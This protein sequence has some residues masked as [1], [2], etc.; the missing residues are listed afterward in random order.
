L[1]S[2]IGRGA[3]PPRSVAAY[4]RFIVVL[5][6]CWPNPAA[7]QPVP[8]AKPQL[9]ITSPAARSVST[10]DVR[11]IARC[12]DDGPSCTVTVTHAGSPLA[13]GAWA[14]DT[15]V[16]PPYHIGAFFIE[17]IDS[18]GQKTSERRT[19]YIHDR[20]LTHAATF[21]E[22]IFDI[23]DDRVL[24]A[25]LDQVTS[26]VRIVDRATNVAQTIWSRPSGE[27]EN[28]RRGYLTPAGAIFIVSGSLGYRLLEWRN[29]G[30]VDLGQ[31]VIYHSNYYGTDDSLVVKG[32]WALFI[33]EPTTCCSPWIGA[34]TLRDLTTGTNTAL[35]PFEIGAYSMQPD[36]ANGRAVYTTSATSPTSV[37]IVAFDAGPP[38]AETLLTDHVEK[39]YWP[40]TDGI[41]VVFVRALDRYEPS[42]IILRTSSG[43]EVV[44]A[45]NLSTPVPDTS[46]RVAGGWVAFVR[47]VGGRRQ[48]WL[49]APDGTERL[50]P[51]TERHPPTFEA[52]NER[53]DVVY[54]LSDFGESKR[55]LARADGTTVEFGALGIPVWLN[56]DWYVY[57]DS[58]LFAIGAAPERA[59]LSEGATGT[60]FTT[61]IAILNPHAH[62]VPA[63]IRYLREGAPEIQETRTLAP[64]SRTT[65]HQD[66]MPGLDGASVSTTVDTPEG[67]PLVVD[68]LMTWNADGYGGHLGS[69]VE[70]PRPRWLFAEGAQG[71]FNTFFLLANSGADEASVRL[72]FLLEQAA[73]VVYT[74]TVGPGARKTVYAGDVPG[75]LNQSF[76]TV[77]E[78]DRPIV[79]E[80]AM[81]FGGPPFWRGGHG[82]AG[83]PEPS[84]TWFHAEGATGP[85]FDTYL[86]LSNPHDHEVE[87]SVSYTTE[88][89]VLVQRPKKLAPLS[90]L[91]INIENESPGLA[92]AAV[93]MRV[94]THGGWPIVSERAMYWGW[95]LPGGWLEAHNSFGITSTGYRWG[96]AEGRAGGPRNY[97]TYVLVSN[98]SSLTAQLRVTFIREDGVSVERLISVGPEQRWT[99]DTSVIP[100]LAGASFSTIVESTNSISIT[101]ESAIYWD[102]NGVTFEGGGNTVATRL[103]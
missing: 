63:T 50:L 80:R 36:V 40:R 97:R 9:I 94:E 15:I 31:V 98:G 4:F 21:P 35:G 12:V 14:L 84:T 58:H 7:A 2:S 95:A 42:S 64:R 57:A 8:D 61:D 73:P 29:G 67:S 33:T 71:Y 39:S 24:V 99:I 1:N 96:L 60:F 6:C 78:S 13:T 81:Y 16:T 10:P 66:D 26:D 101:V 18:A 46:Y 20:K 54:K 27:Y 74:T 44:L 62:P 77:I 90:R 51:L 68:R 45:S 72:T 41:N 43:A 52:M 75:L 25:D 85:F 59:I 11:I 83:V 92:N 79:A 55:V 38:A 37:E 30:I 5:A 91:T 22:T 87:V 49:R 48:G 100:E 17:A 53:G 86:L 89:G 76:A 32:A 65:I 93:S 82:S 69:A 34:L 47:E 3:F 28:P 88:G 70:S 102:A 23:D 56:E 19:V 103:W